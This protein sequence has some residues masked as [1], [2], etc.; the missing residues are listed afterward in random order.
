MACHFQDLV[1]LTNSN[2]RMGGSARESTLTMTA[3]ALDYACLWNGS[4]ME[5][6]VAQM[7][8]MS[9]GIL[10]MVSLSAKLLK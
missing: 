4:V 9:Q 8:V 10:V 6:R 7:G 1:G 5:L 2:A 3:D